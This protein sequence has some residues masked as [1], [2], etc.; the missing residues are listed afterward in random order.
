VNAEDKVVMENIRASVNIMH[1]VAVGIKSVLQ[2]AKGKR[3]NTSA[4]FL[5]IH[6]TRVSRDEK[7]YNSGGL[8]AL[9]REPG[10]AGINRI[11]FAK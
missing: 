8:E 5:E 6:L 10:K 2:R 3:S 11:G 4:G 1:K 9:V 7:R